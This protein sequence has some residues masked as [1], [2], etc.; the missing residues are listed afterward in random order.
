MFTASPAP[1]QQ[2]TH[3]QAAGC[4]LPLWWEQWSTH[5]H[6]SHFCPSPCPAA[7]PL[8][9]PVQ[10]TRRSSKGGFGVSS[11]PHVGAG[12]TDPVL[13]PR[14]LGSS[15]S[16]SE[17]ARDAAKGPNSVHAGWDRQAQRPLPLH[18][19]GC[20]MVLRSKLSTPDI[21]S[22]PCTICKAP[23]R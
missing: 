4:R 8:V 10:S 12:P 22:G 16:H 2:G 17:P 1:H 20:W 19:D 13:R 18:A 15:S 6:Q 3:K 5:S 21:W 23:L 14:C 7:L 9:S 11:A